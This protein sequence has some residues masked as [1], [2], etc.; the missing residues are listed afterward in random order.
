[1]LKQKFNRKDVGEQSGEDAEDRYTQQQA[2]RLQELA[3]KVE[4]FV[5]GQGDLEGARFEE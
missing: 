1:M 3:K 2:A 5:E 4:G